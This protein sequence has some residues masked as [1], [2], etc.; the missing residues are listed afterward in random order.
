MLYVPAGTVDGRSIVRVAFPVPPGPKATAPGVSSTVGPL[1]ETLATRVTLPENPSMPL[2]DRV[3]VGLYPA[4]IGE[5][6]RSSEILK[7]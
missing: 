4:W 3:I 5:S 6:G 7:S 1:G 2:T